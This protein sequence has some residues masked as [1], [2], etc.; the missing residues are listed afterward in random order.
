MSA[1]LHETVMPDVESRDVR[2]RLK[3]LRSILNAPMRDRTTRARLV[4][5]DGVQHELPDPVYRVL[6]DVV[7]AMSQGLGITVIP[8]NTMLT[9]QEAADV[10]GISR[11][12]LVR[13][14]EQG[15]I[16]YEQPGRHRRV[17]LVDVIAYQNRV[18][19]HRRE[20]LRRMARESQDA[21]LHEGVTDGPPPRM[22]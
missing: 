2:M 1:T 10:L 8:Q 16:D 6:R 20:T 21:G 7:E 3:A 12:T 19:D 18:R 14:L 22:R 17:R 15:E 9:T 11:P 4:G 13:L 5:S